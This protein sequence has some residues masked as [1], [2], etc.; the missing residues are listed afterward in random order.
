MSFGDAVAHSE[1]FGTRHLILGNG[2]SIGCR[3][4]IFYYASL[5]AEADC[6]AIPEVMQVLDGLQTQDFEGEF[7]LSPEKVNL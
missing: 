1:Q 3:A 4:E 6:S 5:F 2:I 7:A